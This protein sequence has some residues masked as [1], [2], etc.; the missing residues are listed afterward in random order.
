MKKA[1][2]LILALFAIAFATTAR[3]EPRVFE[4]RVV[5]V[6]DG[7]TI[8]VLSKGKLRVRVR[9]AEIDAPESSQDFGS[10]AKQVL[11]DACFGKTAKVTS[12]KTD[13]Y[14]RV[15]GRVY[16]D[17]LDAQEHLLRN[18]MAWVYDSYVQDRSLYSFQEEAKAARR[19]LW[20][21]T[22]SVPPWEFRRSTRASSY[23]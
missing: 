21:H 22:N 10:R 18:G 12:A 23:P 19:G 13:R 2:S 6:S 9:L 8:T 20:A 1:Y 3:S 4:G 15:V 11:S 16:C 5:G 14:G 17:G 7:D